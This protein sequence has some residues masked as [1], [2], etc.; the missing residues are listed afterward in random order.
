VRGNRYCTSAVQQV[1][2]DGPAAT[3]CGRKSGDDRADTA[4]DNGPDYVLHSSAVSG[5]LYG[6]FP[7]SLNS[8]RKPISLAS[9]KLR[10]SHDAVALSR[11]VRGAAE[12]FG[13]L[14]RDVGGL[15]AA[16][17]ETAQAIAEYPEVDAEIC[18]T[19]E[20]ALQLA[21]RLPRA[22]PEERA[23]ATAHLT[24]RLAGLRSL[25]DEL[26]IQEIRSRVVVH[27]RA[28]FPA[29]RSD[30]IQSWA[31]KGTPETAQFEDDDI[32]A[33]E[34][35]QRY[36]QLC[37]GYRELLEELQETNRGVVA[38]HA[39]LE[40]DI[41]ERRRLEDDLRR[42]A[43][44]LSS[45]NRTKEDF[46]ATLSHELRTPLNAM[47]GW[48][49]LLR[50]GRL[51]GSAM[52]RALETIERNARIQEQLIA[53]I[54]DVSRIV[55]GKL[56]LELRPLELAPLVQAALDAIG[57]A[58]EAKGIQLESSIEFHGSVLGDPDRLQQV[59]W[60][61]VVNAIK[62][63][64]RGGRVAVTLDQPGASAVVTVSDTGEGISS[65][66]LPFVFDRFT[67]GDTSVT[68]LH[69]GLG[70]GLSIVRHIVELHGGR[71]QA[72][73]DG[74][75]R[76]SMFSVQ[77]PVRTVHQTGEQVD[78]PSQ[79]RQVASLFVVDDHSDR[80]ERPRRRVK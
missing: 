50:M 29:T 16:A 75:G 66:L 21:Y 76:G 54:L 48:T 22:G 2:S 24:R 23:A 31:L 67:Q 52:E 58:A 8:A 3:P 41:T 65:E 35:P 72:H 43:E 14:P 39:E 38:L 61:L 1:S 56:R 47:L 32:P 57:P 49:R 69:G 26:E 42:R 40:R 51:E 6:W 64:P 79:P 15:S 33:S 28:R 71:V 7:L 17:Y 37:Q 78:V 36:R 60:N 19:D 30:L 13:L 11:R 18:L 63:T 27:L 20:P 5:G 80:R 70:L 74:K 10:T 55:T 68:R 12:R 77:L 53:D 9:V 46:L 25:V 34:L 62:F 45:A 4:T 44:E 73:S 59:I